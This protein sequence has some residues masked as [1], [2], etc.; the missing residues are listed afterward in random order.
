MKLEVS[1]WDG[2]IARTDELDDLTPDGVAAALARLDGRQC[3]ELSLSDEDPYR[4]FNVGGGPQLFLLTGE[5]ED[6]Q[7]LQLSDPNAGDNPVG[8]V[9]GGQLATYPRSDLVQRDAVLAVLNR[10]IAG[11]GYDPALPWRIE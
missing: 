11:A 3:T 7:I 10:F 5:D 8:L 2:P 1:R 9:T 6:E 4:Y